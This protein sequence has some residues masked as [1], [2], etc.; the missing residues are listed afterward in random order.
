MAAKA[1]CF[2]RATVTATVTGATAATVTMPAMADI[3]A[4]VQQLV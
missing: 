3:A 4:G 1:T 2:R